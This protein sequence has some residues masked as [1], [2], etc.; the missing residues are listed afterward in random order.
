MVSDPAV[1][2]VT[3]LE[4]VLLLRMSNSITTAV[5]SADATVLINV[6]R[7]FARLSLKKTAGA[8]SA[9]TDQMPATMH[10]PT[11]TRTALKPLTNRCLKEAPPELHA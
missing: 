7:P 10:A 3:P 9:G 11:K 1:M 8:D 4:L 2:V 6:L 5:A